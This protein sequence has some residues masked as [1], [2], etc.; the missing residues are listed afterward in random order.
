LPF[1]VGFSGGAGVTTKV[2]GPFGCI[3]GVGATSD[4]VMERLGR[5]ASCNEI[6]TSWVAG[7]D[8]RLP[9][10]GRMGRQSS[11]SSA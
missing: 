4:D 5:D 6:L 1:E 10:L 9:D 8:R 2:G 3:L 7:N 11:L